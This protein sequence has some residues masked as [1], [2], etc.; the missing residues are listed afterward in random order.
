MV[1]ICPMTSS[2]ATEPRAS[3]VWPP[4]DCATR[5]ALVLECMWTKLHRQFFLWNLWNHFSLV[6]SFK[7]VGPRRITVRTGCLGLSFWVLSTNW[8]GIMC[9]THHAT[10]L[11]N[12]IEQECSWE[13]LVLM[14][15]LSSF[16]EFLK[17]HLD[18]ARCKRA[19]PRGGGT[20]HLF[21]K[22]MHANY[23]N[24]VV[25][26][27]YILHILNIHWSEVRDTMPPLSLVLSFQW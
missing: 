13:K 26:V 3:R 11:I 4:C 14:S 12:N 17:T 23:M 8:H 22:H 18:A 20:L 21:W 15:F 24:P 27:F 16:P 10:S 25:C 9:I 1:E 6:R 7:G 2:A 5:C 19:R